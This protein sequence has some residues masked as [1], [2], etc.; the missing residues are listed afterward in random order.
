MQIYWSQGAG[1][2]GISTAIWA[3]TRRAMRLTVV[4]RTGAGNAASLWQRRVCWLR[5]RV[6][7]VT[8][9][10]LSAKRRDACWTGRAFVLRLVLSS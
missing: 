6:V 4:D 9:R 7:P 2:V 3:A 5:W 8:V 1:I 10:G